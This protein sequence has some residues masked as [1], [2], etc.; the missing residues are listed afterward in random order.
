MDFTNFTK[1][2]EWLVL[3]DLL[4]QEFSNYIIKTNGKSNE[5]IV[6]EAKGNEYAKEKVENFI[7]KIEVSSLSN[8][9]NQTYK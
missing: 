4:R 6:T 8:T 5:E 3:K 9:R 2:E 1:T 7:K